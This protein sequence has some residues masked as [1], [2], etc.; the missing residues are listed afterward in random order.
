MTP[1]Y[2]NEWTE[3]D[4]GSGEII[5]HGTFAQ[6]AIDTETGKPVRTKKIL[7]LFD[8]TGQWSKPYADAGYQV[9]TLDIQGGA[10]RFGGFDLTQFTCWEDLNEFLDDFDMHGVD[11]IL[12]AVP[13]TDFSVSGARWWKGKDESGSTS[14]S[15]SLARLTLDIIEVLKPA[16]WV[17]EN[18]VGRLPKLVPELQ[19]FG[20]FYFQPCDYGDPYTKKTGLWGEFSRELIQTPVEPTEGSKMWKI[21]PGPER[22]NL[23]SA[24]PEGFAKAFFQANP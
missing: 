5:R 20:P 9:F 15:I 24:T 17:I 11:G 22:A 8:T 12:A 6:E 21:P 7:S 10:N 2:I 16:W 4:D 1:L 3:D 23:R 19:E 18:P 14:T 13:C